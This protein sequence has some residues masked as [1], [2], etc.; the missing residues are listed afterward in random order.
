MIYFF[1]VLNK[2]ETEI[3]DLIKGYKANEGLET[4]DSHQEV[5]LPF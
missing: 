5:D 3:V 2:N 4:H 1:I